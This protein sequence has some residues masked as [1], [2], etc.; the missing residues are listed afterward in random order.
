MH[1]KKGMLLSTQPIPGQITAH[2]TTRG[3]LYLSWR[4]V[5]IATPRPGRLV[6]LRITADA[7]PVD[8]RAK[9]GRRYLPRLQGNA[10]RCVP[11]QAW[12]L[13]RQ[14]TSKKKTNNGLD[15]ASSR[16]ESGLLLTKENCTSPWPR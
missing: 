6:R 9:H 8:S 12:R 7:Y 15:P 3:E 11:T 5:Q 2:L 13:A 1:N 16:A 10:W 4:G 14:R